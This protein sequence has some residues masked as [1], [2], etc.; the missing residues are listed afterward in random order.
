[1][2]EITIKPFPDEKASFCGIAEE[3]PCCVCGLY[4]ENDVHIIRAKGMRTVICGTCMVK[5]YGE[6]GQYVHQKTVARGEM[7]ELFSTHGIWDIRHITVKDV[8]TFGILCT[9][10]NSSWAYNIH[11][12]TDD[13]E[14]V[15]CSFYD[16][17]KTLFFSKEYAEK[18]LAYLADRQSKA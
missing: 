7:W 9:D 18:A 15:Y 3:E 1:M 6:L 8:F 12:E 11:A 17:G 14:Q 4:D 13:G 16:E 5:L 2:N 10:G